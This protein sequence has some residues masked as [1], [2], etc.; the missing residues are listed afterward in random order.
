MT[1]RRLI[2]PSMG[3]E[4]M[5]FI[6]PIASSLYDESWGSTPTNLCIWRFAWS[7]WPIFRRITPFPS[8]EVSCFN[9]F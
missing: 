5:D 2:L 7:H 1:V 6:L 4:T 9:F 3:Y 8:I